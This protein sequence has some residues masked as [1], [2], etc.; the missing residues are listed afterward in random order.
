MTNA[1]APSVGLKREPNDLTGGPAK[2]VAG[3]VEDDEGEVYSDPDEG[4]EIIDMENVRSMDWMAPESLRKEKQKGK[5]RVKEDEDGMG[6]ARVDVDVP[7]FEPRVEGEGQDEAGE[8]KVNL[9][10][11]LNLSDSEEDE[12]EEF[13]DMVEEFSRA[14]D[15]DVVSLGPRYYTGRYVPLN[16]TNVCR[17]GLPH[18]NAFI[19]F[20]SRIR[21]RNSFLPQLRLRAKTIRGK[22]RRQKILP[23]APLLVARRS[24]SRLMSSLPLRQHPLFLPKLLARSRQKNLRKM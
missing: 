12:E 2:K 1:G 16:D 18:A 17:T 14:M 15:M 21:S 9:A 6:V 7:E 8:S 13:V 19:S 22:P 24:L 10:N 23:P 5:K 4:V 3:E 20:N 11:A